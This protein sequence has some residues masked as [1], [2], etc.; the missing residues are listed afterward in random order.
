[1]N[2]VRVNKSDHAIYTG[3]DDME[4]PTN[5]INLVPIPLGLPYVK[6]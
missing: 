3:T 1:M 6:L 4:E 5:L 2:Y